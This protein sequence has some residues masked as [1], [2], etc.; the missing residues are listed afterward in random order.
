MCTPCSAQC[1]QKKRSSGSSSTSTHFLFISQLQP[2]HVLVYSL[3]LS[4]SGHSV[5]S[6]TLQICALVAA[7]PPSCLD[8]DKSLTEV[9]TARC[10]PRCIINCTSLLARQ[11]SDHPWRTVDQQRQVGHRRSYL[12]WFS[13]ER[14]RGTVDTSASKRSMYLSP[15]FAEV[16]TSFRSDLSHCFSSFLNKA[17]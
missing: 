8:L 6:V 4:Y 9:A 16:K 12:L 11:L 14:E 17:F 1:I 5:V 2:D 3:S 15:S 10:Q 13:L 7:R